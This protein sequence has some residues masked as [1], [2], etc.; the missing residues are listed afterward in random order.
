MFRTVSALTLSIVNLLALSGCKGRSS[1][2]AAQAEDASASLSTAPA[3]SHEPKAGPHSRPRGDGGARFGLEERGPVDASA[4]PGASEPPPIPLAS[5]KLEVVALGRTY[6]S[7]IL[8][9]QAVGKRF[10]LSGLNVD[11]FADGDGPLVKGPDILAK[12]P[13]KPGVHSMHVV[14][15]WP[16]LYALRTKNVEGRMESPEPTLFVYHSDD[17]PGTWTEAKPLGMS[18][19]PHAFVAWGEGAVVM[20]SAIQFN[21]GPYLSPGEVATSLSYLAPDGSVSDPGLPIPKDF[22][23]WTAESD[24]TTLSLLGTVAL[25]MKKP[26]EFAGT[27]G[28]HL[29]RVTKDGAKRT[30]IRSTEGDGTLWLELYRSRVLERGGAALVTPGPHVLTDGWKPS[31]LSTF[32]VGEDGK[33]RVRTFSGNEFCSLDSAQPV[34]AAIY[35]IRQ[36]FGESGERYDLV[37][38]DAGGKTEKVPLPRIVKNAA[39]GFRVAT[40]KEKGAIE[41]NPTSIAVREPDDVWVWAKCGGNPAIWDRGPAVPVLLRRGRP[42]EPIVIP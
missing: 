29:V 1:P 36:C 33:P 7:R 21:A 30:L 39:G 20:T 13:Y 37:R 10:W 22:L 19:F 34:G 9:A 38:L 18:W 12:L 26:D 32:S 14:G 16:R 23:A 35:G 28:V 27:S 11:A 15:A 25:P 41:C 8:W 31:A 17:G 5:D 2:A 4:P 6:N 24:G 40:A 3:G 42:Q